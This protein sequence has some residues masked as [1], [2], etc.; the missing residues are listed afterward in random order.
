MWLG[1]IAY[2]LFGLSETADLKCYT[3]SLTTDHNGNVIGLADVDCYDLSNGDDYVIDC[4][5][6]ATVCGTELIAD[7]M[8]N[9]EQVFN[10]GGKFKF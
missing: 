10:H 4:W 5:I 3:C 9:G 7:W 2:S 1:I 8:P 6:G